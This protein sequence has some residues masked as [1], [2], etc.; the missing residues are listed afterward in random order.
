MKVSPDGKVL[1]IEIRFT[2]TNR[3][4]KFQYNLGEDTPEGI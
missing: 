1:K 4:I 2:E 3:E